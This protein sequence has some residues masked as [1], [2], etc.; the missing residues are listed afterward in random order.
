MGQIKGRHRPSSGLRAV[1]QE[2]LLDSLKE[3][4][5]GLVTL[6]PRLLTL[7]AILINVVVGIA[8]L[9]NSV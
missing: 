5:R 7:G 9:A 1:E 8:I 3:P 4:L 2:Q 6:V